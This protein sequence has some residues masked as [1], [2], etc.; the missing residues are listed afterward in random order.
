VPGGLPIEMPSQR[1]GGICQTSEGL[2][3]SWAHFLSRDS[4][5]PRYPL[6]KF[7]R[8]WFASSKNMK[9]LTAFNPQSAIGNPPF[10]LLRSVTA[11]YRLQKILAGWR[12]AVRHDV[13]QTLMQA[14]SYFQYH[15]RRSAAAYGRG[16]RY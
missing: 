9:L 14:M 1:D 8:P 4:R 10:G 12:L 11:S 3:L 16:S 13:G 6:H 7:L 2:D 5:N 15:L